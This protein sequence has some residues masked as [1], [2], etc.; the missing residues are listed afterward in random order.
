MD[1]NIFNLIKFKASDHT[2][3][4]N[5]RRLGRPLIV[6]LGDTGYQM[7]PAIDLRERCEQW[8]TAT[9]SS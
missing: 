4:L 9:A 5:G 7:H 1:T 6:H 2:Y 3:H 8:L